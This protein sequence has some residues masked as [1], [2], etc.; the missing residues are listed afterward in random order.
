[1]KWRTP[2]G[3]LVH[4]HR[5]IE[6]LISLMSEQLVRTAALSHADPHFIDAATD[7]IR[8]YADRCHHGKEE[9]IL[10]RKLAE[11]DLPPDLSGTMQELVQEHVYARNV[12][13]NLVSANAIYIVGDEAA[14]VTIESTMQELVDFYPKHIDK[15]DHHFFKQCLDYLSAEEQ[16]QMLAE[17]DEFDKNLIHETYWG[18]VDSLEAT[19]L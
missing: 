5:V 3:P 12:T 2:T 16:A 13:S 6:R 7:F 4:E 9:N 1:M 17:Y 14:L 8:T 10:F 15:E 18:V 19:Y 11:K